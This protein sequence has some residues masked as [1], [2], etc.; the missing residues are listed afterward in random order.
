MTKEF[1]DNLQDKL[2]YDGVEAKLFLTCSESTQIEHPA[3]FELSVL[4][5][6]ES[7]SKSM[8]LSLSKAKLYS[9]QYEKFDYYC[10]IGNDGFP[11][12]KDWLKK[13]VDGQKETGCA[14]MCPNNDK[15]GLHMFKHHFINENDMY[16]HVKMFPA[17][18]WLIPKEIITRVGYFDERFIPGCYEDD[19]YARRVRNAGGTIYVR[20]DVMITHRLSQTLGKMGAREAMS[21]NHQR[22]KEKWKE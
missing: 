11:Q 15:P 21:K 5:K 16:V 22:Y 9:L 8:N 20:R 19:D 17:I 10:I 18:C 2:V 7:F 4:D 12:Q 14:I 13:L 6:N 1:L 3:I